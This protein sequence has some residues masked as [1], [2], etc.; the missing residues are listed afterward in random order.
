MRPTIDAAAP[1]VSAAPLSTSSPPPRLPIS[2]PHGTARPSRSRDAFAHTPRTHARRHARTH[3]RTH[4][5][6]HTHAGTRN[7]PP[8]RAL[9]VSGVMRVPLNVDVAVVPD[10]TEPNGSSMYVLID[11]GAA[12][13]RRPP[14]PNQTP[15]GRGA[16]ITSRRRPCRRTLSRTTTGSSS[17][18]CGARTRPRLCSRRMPATP[19]RQA[20]RR[21][22]RQRRM[23]PSRTE[24]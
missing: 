6:T 7:P 20:D 21:T 11:P 16:P 19:P 17:L 12:N 8:L 9:Q 2:L 3:A 22:P 23:P 5:Y 1:E 10:P 15:C 14:S 18:G 4:T 13:A 24:A